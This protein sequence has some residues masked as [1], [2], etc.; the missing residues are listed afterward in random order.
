MHYFLLGPSGVGKTTFG[1]W[2]G[3]RRY[4]HIP[5]DRPD[6]RDGIDVAGLRDLW[7]KLGQG[8]P[9]PMADELQD[10]AD[11]KGK[12]GCV[13]TFPSVTFFPLNWVDLLA[14]HDIAVRYLYGHKELCITAFLGRERHPQRDRAFWLH[15]N[16]SYEAMGAADLA[17]YRV[18]TITLSK[19]RRKGR[20]IG[21]R[22]TGRE[23]AKRLNIV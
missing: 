5:I 18:D 13:L 8:D 6:R 17:P 23:I 12:K 10:R 16:K 14:K 15:N 4:L 1:D 11:A 2:L 7:N 9:G 22:L 19:K 3:A 21:K 20:R